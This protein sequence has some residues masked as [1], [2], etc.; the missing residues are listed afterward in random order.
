MHQTGGLQLLLKRR[1]TLKDGSLEFQGEHRDALLAVLS[2]L[3]ISAKK[4]G[5]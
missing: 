5:S 2:A 3:G 1:G 4:S